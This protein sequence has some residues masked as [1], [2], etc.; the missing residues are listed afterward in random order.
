MNTPH[1]HAEPRVRKIRIRQPRR[2]RKVDVDD[3]YREK[4]EEDVEPQVAEAA[5]GVPWVDGA[6]GVAV[7]EEDVLLEDRLFAGGGLVSGGFRK[8]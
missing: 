3:E 6:V 8:G 4:R 2:V 7:P 1:V 5:V